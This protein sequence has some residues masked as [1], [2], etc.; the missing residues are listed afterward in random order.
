VALISLC[1][2]YLGGASGPITF[3]WILQKPTLMVNNPM[4]G[5]FLTQEGVPMVGL[6]KHVFVQGRAQQP[7]EVC[8]LDGGGA[9]ARL[10]PDCGY[11]LEENTQVEIEAA[12]VEL[13]RLIA[14]GLGEHLVLSNGGF[15]TLAGLASRYTGFS[16]DGR[17][18]GFPQV[19]MAFERAI[20]ETYTPLMQRVFSRFAENRPARLGLFGAATTGRQVLADFR[21]VVS[22]EIQFFDNDPA[23]QGTALDGV[24][25]H[26]PSVLSRESIDLVVLTSRSDVPA[27]D[28][29]LRAQGWVRGENLF[30]HDDAAP[31]PGT[32][33]FNRDL[34]WNVR[35]SAE[36]YLGERLTPVTAS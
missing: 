15:T 9:P 20:R 13:E 7:T 17:Q 10:A 5:A 4:L 3:A 24:T 27:L 8:M 30:H 32:F 34:C 28:E 35:A 25:I 23:R 12:L 22:W 14:G 31:V 1:R 11:A 6:E 36:R 18:T 33:Q 16:F 2:A 19:F 21:R 26:S 29:R